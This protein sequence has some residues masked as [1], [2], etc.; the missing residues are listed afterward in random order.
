MTTNGRVLL[1]VEDGIAHVRLN[2]GDKRN[3][4]DREYWEAV[5]R[6]ELIVQRCNACGV[7]QWGP[8]L[9]CYRCHSF[10]LGWKRVSGR[11]RLFSWVRTW[12]PVHSALR[13]ACPYIVAVVT[14]PDADDVR[15]V[16]NLIGDPNQN[17]PFDA[18][19]EA[20][21]E[22]HGDATLVQWRVRS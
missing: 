10:D 21:F 5:K 7:A 3:G 17:P 2:R 11:G 13:S 15:M 9:I 14:L 18:E 1:S 16:G 20:V 8:E 12:Y 4:L 6:H 22:D 19:V